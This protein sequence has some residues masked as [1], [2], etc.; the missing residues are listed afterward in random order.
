VR[1]QSVEGELALPWDCDL[2]AS[3]QTLQL[4]PSDYEDDPPIVRIPE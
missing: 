1:S 3:R 2:E 4:V